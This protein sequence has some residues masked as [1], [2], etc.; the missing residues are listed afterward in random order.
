MCIFPLSNKILE[1]CVKNCGRRFHVLVCT[2]DFAQE[3]VRL[4]GNAVH[5]CQH[6]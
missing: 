1:T 3:L 6:H 4:I 5:Y 2:K